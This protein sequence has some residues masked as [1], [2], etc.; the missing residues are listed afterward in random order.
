MD[1]L[2]A[3]AATMRY[4]SVLSEWRHIASTFLQNRCH[5]AVEKLIFM[6]DLVLSLVFDSMLATRCF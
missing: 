4:C 5:L 6:V 2:Q 1:W 3:D